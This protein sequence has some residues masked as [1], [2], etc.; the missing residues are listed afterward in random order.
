V[1]G[2]IAAIAHSRSLTLVTATTE[3]FRHFD[4]LELVDWIR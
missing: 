2:Q 3:D 4:E 1:D